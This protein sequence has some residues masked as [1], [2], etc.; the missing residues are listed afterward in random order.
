MVLH[1][2]HR[3]TTHNTRQQ[4]ASS[5][6][7]HYVFLKPE[8]ERKNIELFNGVNDVNLSCILDNSSVPEKK[9]RFFLKK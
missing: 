5:G 4:V 9:K 3:Q 7:L 6:D 8:K 2:S 1:C